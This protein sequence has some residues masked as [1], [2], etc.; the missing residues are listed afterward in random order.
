M[1]GGRPTQLGGD[2]PCRRAKGCS[3]LLA[4]RLW[5]LTVVA[6]KAKAWANPIERPK[7]FHPGLEV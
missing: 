4:C 2:S 1:W 3:K 5:P 7:D 6:A